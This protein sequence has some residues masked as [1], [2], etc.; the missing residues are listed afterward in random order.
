M[1]RSPRP[2]RRRASPA[3]RVPPTRRP[4]LTTILTR[5][6]KTPPTIHNRAGRFPHGSSLLDAPDGGPYGPPSFIAPAKRAF[7]RSCQRP[8]VSAIPTEPPKAPLSFQDLI[9]TLHQYWGD[10]G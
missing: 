1:I 10:Q 8:D 3:S 9:L 4:R 2:R 6:R 5:M 7:S